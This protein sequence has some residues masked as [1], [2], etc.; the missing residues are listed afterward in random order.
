MARCQGIMRAK[1][2]SGFE[3]RLSSIDFG[4]MSAGSSCNAVAASSRFFLKSRKRISS[5]RDGRRRGLRMIFG[6]SLSEVQADAWLA[7]GQVPKADRDAM[8]AASH[9]SAAA[10][11][12]PL[13]P[14][15]QYSRAADPRRR[16]KQR[17]AARRAACR[18]ARM[19]P[20]A[21]PSQPSKPPWT[22]VR[23]RTSMKKLRSASTLDTKA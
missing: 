11:T 13:P 19:Q 1:V 9:A 6:H 3:A 15:V 18:P 20:T 21:I 22:L 12:Q 14:R 16:D 17:R 23:G 8:M 5:S 7:W 2:S 4:A 10:M